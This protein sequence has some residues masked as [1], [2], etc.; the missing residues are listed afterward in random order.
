[1]LLILFFFTFAYKNVKKNIDA[2]LRH[3]SNFFFLSNENTLIL[4]IQYDFNELEL[5]RK[6][7]KKHIFLPDIHISR[8]RVLGWKSLPY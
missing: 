1:M 8:K 4:E 3:A 6:L 5:F 2:S 7:K